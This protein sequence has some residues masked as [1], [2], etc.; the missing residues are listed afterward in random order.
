MLK[1]DPADIEVGVVG[2][3]LMGSSI[4]VSLLAAGHR[5][6]AIAPITDD[7]NKAEKRINEQLHNCQHAGLLNA[8]PADCLSKLQIT[9]DYASL[10][11]CALVME[12]VIEDISI[13]S[14]VYKKIT[15]VVAADAV[16]ASNTSAIAI[17]ILQKLVKNPERFLGIH[18]AEPA[19][20]T[21]FLE[22]TC[23]E[24]TNATYADAVFN[25]AHKWGKE[26]TLLRKD[27]KGFITNRLM[28]A[29]YR[30]I[31]HLIQQQKTN[32]D[33]AD[34]AIRYGVGSWITLMGLFRRIDY[35]GLGDYAEIFK[36][37]FPQLSNTDAV[38]EVMQKIVKEN[39]RGI[40]NLNGLYNYTN[41]EAAEWEHAFAAFNEDIFKLAAMYPA[42]VAEKEN[43]DP[44]NIIA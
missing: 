21:R 38:P 16:I 30:E 42:T 5:V 29:V 15:D 3:G 18:F 44:S 41:E 24:G 17:T 4:I 27:I 33:D 32:M 10:A 34:K 43:F 22:I 7:F 35:E 23:G 12:C 36:N 14:Q 11:N 37:L 8:T 2:I 6:K 1:T 31:F 13:K 20:A 28:Y 40:Q 9:M 25:L 39:G 26:P 19:Y